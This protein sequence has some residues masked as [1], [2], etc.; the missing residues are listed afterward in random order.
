[1]A[2]FS[3]T[4]VYGRTCYLH[5]V[6]GTGGRPRHV[7][8]T[9]AAGAETLLPTGFEVRENVNGQVSVRRRR[10]R[11]FAVEREC[12]SGETDWLRLEMLSLLPA[13]RQYLPHAGRDSFFDLV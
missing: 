12:F 13:L 2:P 7:M 3:C 4:T 1:M 11:H 9:C 8:G 6:R 10:A 5:V